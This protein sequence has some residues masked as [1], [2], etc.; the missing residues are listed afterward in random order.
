MAETKEV[1]LKEPGDFVLPGDV[2]AYA[3]EFAPG[4]GTHE[5]GEHVCAS[6]TGIFERDDDE[7][8][9][10][11][12][13]IVSTP[14]EVQTGD[15]VVVYINRTRS[16]MAIGEV[17]SVAGKED[18]TISGEVEATLHISK[19]SD[20]YVEEIGDV[21]KVGDIIKAKVLSHDPSIQITTVGDDYG[22]IRAYC[23]R[24]RAPTEVKGQGLECPNCEFNE[25]RK[26]S[27]DYGKGMAVDH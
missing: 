21:Y 20:D 17:M 24:C 15:E 26:L 11:I 16:S 12:R 23:G 1:K 25:R 18:R 4:P 14:V 27:K 5:D 9:V 2:L 7:R 13:P 8:T 3:V 6:W 22:V 19:I 10:R